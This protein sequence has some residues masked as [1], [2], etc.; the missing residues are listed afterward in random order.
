MKG[1]QTT[2]STVSTAFKPRRI[3]RTRSTASAIVLYI[4]QFPAM[5]GLRMVFSFC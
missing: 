4:F 5:I 2:E 1:G 3:S